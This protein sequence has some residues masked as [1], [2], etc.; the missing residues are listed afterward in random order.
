MQP[1]GGSELEAESPI[2][3]STLLA[4]SRL[5]TLGAIVG[6]EGCT[7]GQV[8]STVASTLSPRQLC[9]LRLLLCASEGAYG[10]F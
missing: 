10:G 8:P 6:R 2:P 5:P 4:G 9:Q 7:Q 1:L 3:G